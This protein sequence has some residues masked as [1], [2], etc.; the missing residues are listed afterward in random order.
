MAR[1]AKTLFNTNTN[2]NKINSVFIKKISNTTLTGIY[3]NDD[4]LILI[5]TITSLNNL[6]STGHRDELTETLSNTYFNQLSHEIYKNSLSSPNS[7]INKFIISSL[8]SLMQTTFNHSKD[9]NFLLKY[10]N[11]YDILN[12]IDLLKDYL[13]GI[14]A[15][16]EQI[17]VFPQTKITIAPASLKQEYQIYV[18]QYGFPANGIFDANL[19]GQIVYNFNVQTAAADEAATAALIYNPTSNN[20]VLSPVTT[21]DI[22]LNIIYTLD[23]NLL[24]L[25][26]INTSG[27]TGTTG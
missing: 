7:P 13:K 19:L 3:I 2:T 8:T 21:T 20:T 25:P 26:T 5:N 24:T 4:S 10:K 23:D 12:D 1:Y 22:S 11:S 6:I 9:T 14:K 27:P 16:K 17:S 18:D 15:Q